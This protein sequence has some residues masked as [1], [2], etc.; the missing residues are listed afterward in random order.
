[1]ASFS[2]PQVVQVPV[3]RSCCRQ[4]TEL[5]ERFRKLR[6]RL[7]ICRAIRR[8]KMKLQIAL[9]STLYHVKGGYSTVETWPLSIA[10][11]AAFRLPKPSRH[12]IGPSP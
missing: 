10:G 8:E 4:T 5:I 2:L 9:A 12:T 11:K 7:N 3:H 1:M 6:N